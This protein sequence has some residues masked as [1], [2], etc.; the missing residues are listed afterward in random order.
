MSTPDPHVQ[1]ASIVVDVPADKAYR[2]MASGL[3]QAN[4]ALGSWDRKEAEG[5]VFVG[6][7]RFSYK[8]LFVRLV[9]DDD[10]LL[11]D[12]FTG[13]SP[14]DLVWRVQSRV[15][16]GEL[17]GYTDQQCVVTIIK[18]RPKDLSDAEWLQQH[19]VWQTE[20]QLIK[21]RLEHV[22]EG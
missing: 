4:W 22:Y 18:W 16:P 17:L 6:V 1:A 5:D 19:H 21:G 9:G 11:V 10:K 7:S 12:Y 14:D 20:V 13:S 15:V 2:F 8:E 3:E